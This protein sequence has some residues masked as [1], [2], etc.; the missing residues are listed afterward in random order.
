MLT[1]YKN[2]PNGKVLYAEYWMEEG[3]VVEHT[4][5][6]GTYGTTTKSDFPVAYCNEDEFKSDFLKRFID[7]GY[8][9]AS[10]QYAY[11]LLVQYPMKS[12]SGSKRDLW[13]KDKASE[14]LIGELGWKGLG[15]VDG[16]DMG[17]TANPITEFALNIYCYV[18]DEKL[19]IQ[20]IKR[21]LKETRLDYTR[22]KIASRELNNDKEYVLKYSAKKDQE[23]YV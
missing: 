14:A 17:K 21:V 1:L 11:I 16:H 23:F 2:E 3:Q 7:Q 22:I 15:V 9:Q 4:G 8:E 20:A 13:L 6:V 12:I 10:N 18:V 5:T 19:G